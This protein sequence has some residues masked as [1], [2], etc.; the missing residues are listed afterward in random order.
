MA[1]ILDDA[2]ADNSHAGI[3]LM[4][5]VGVP[6]ASAGHVAGDPDLVAKGVARL[7]D[8]AARTDAP[9]IHAPLL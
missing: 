6:L 4:H 8:L 5:A 7:D 9:A 3:W 1:N 2:F